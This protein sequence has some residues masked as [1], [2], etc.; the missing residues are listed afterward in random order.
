[1]AEAAVKQVKEAP[2]AAPAKRTHRGGLPALFDRDFERLFD[3]L[4]RDDD[5]HGLFDVPSLFRR[6]FPAL[7][8]MR[9]AKV[10][11]YQTDDEVVVKAELPG[12]AKEDVDISL[13]DSTLTIKGEK[14]REEKVE[15]DDY[16]RS[17]RS[18]G[19]ISRTIEL[20]CEVAADRVTAKMTNGV[21][22][23]HAP[24][25]EDSKRKPVKVK[26]A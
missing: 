15:E 1:M 21:L 23:I 16:V 14:K 19:M 24:K 7:G 6:S 20:P 11:V 5:R 2:A 10:D 3:T 4:L 26:I 8:E 22:E 13:A 9:L 18:F 25:T 12:L 17:E